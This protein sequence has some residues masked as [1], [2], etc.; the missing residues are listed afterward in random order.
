[1]FRLEFVVCSQE[2]LKTLTLKPLTLKHVQ[3]FNL[4]LEYVIV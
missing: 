1:M 3:F 2:P 4:C